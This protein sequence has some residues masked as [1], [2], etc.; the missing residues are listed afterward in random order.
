M[1]FKHKWSRTNVLPS[2]EW[3]LLIDYAEACIEEEKKNGAEFAWTWG[4]KG[5]DLTAPYLRKDYTDPSSCVAPSGFIRFNAL[6]P[7]GYCGRDFTFNQN[8]SHPWGDIKIEEGQYP[9]DIEVHEEV[10]VARSNS[11]KEK[12]YE[13]VIR[14]ILIKA[15]ILFGERFD[16]KAL[17]EKD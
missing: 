14:K 13:R 6:G 15:K 16:V 8:R 7:D 11:L 3:N 12:P 17:N 4:H 1:P 9:N 10:S 2:K 5:D